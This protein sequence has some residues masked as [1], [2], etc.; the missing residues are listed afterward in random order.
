MIGRNQLI[1]KESKIYRDVAKWIF[2]ENLW[3]NSWFSGARKITIEC[4]VIS[5]SQIFRAEL[6][7]SSQK[8]ITFWGDLAMCLYLPAQN[9]SHSEETWLSD[10]SFQPKIYPILRGPDYVIILSS[11]KPISFWLT[12]WLYSKQGIPSHSEGTWLCDFILWNEV[13]PILRGLDK[14]IVS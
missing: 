14:V 4:I 10:Y 9:L 8:S 3:L 13:Y 1:P 11:Q 7:L 5:L 2:I 6:I 12:T